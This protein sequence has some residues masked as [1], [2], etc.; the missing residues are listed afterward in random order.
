MEKEWIHPLQMK[1]TKYLF[2]DERW[3]LSKRKA[4]TELS[5]WIPIIFPSQTIFEN[6]SSLLIIKTGVSF[7]GTVGHYVILSTELGICLFPMMSLWR[8]LLCKCEYVTAGFWFNDIFSIS[9]FFTNNCKFWSK[10]FPK[11]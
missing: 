10:A 6:N 8:F 4:N 2:E 3:K 1:D 5:H 9:S 7:A 11:P